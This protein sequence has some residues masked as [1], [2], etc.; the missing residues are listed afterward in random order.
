MDPGRLAERVLIAGVRL[1]RL[2]LGPFRISLCRFTPS[3]STYAIESLREHGAVRG[4]WLTIKRLSRCR[5][6]G[7]HGFDPV[8]EG[9][10]ACPRTN[11]TRRSKGSASTSDRCAPR[12]SSGE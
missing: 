6:F 12:R 1:Y 7:G 9:A 11:L 8:P 10:A 2:A 5:P 4:S 3:C